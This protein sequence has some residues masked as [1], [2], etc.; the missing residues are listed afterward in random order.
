MKNIPIGEVLKEYGYI[1]SEQLEEALLYQ[2]EHRDKRLGAVMLE[3]GF[4]DE[5]QMLTAL[6]KRLDLSLTDLHEIDIDTEAVAQI[7]RQIA[8]K[9]K[10]IAVEGKDSELT[11]VMN[12]PLNFYAIEDVRQISQKNIKIKLDVLDNIDNAIKK[13]YGAVGVKDSFNNIGA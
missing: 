11:V 13:N 9:Y 6:A 3:L 2:K 5:K 1:N 12:D 10:M 8:E 7:P 4:V